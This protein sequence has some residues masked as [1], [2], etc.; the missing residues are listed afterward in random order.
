[1]TNISTPDMTYPV[2]GPIAAIFSSPP[3]LQSQA[4]GRLTRK[5][6]DCS[7]VEV[8]LKEEALDDYLIRLL[9]T[10]QDFHIATTPGP[11]G[12]IFVD[13]ETIPGLKPWQKEIFEKAVDRK[14][15]FGDFPD[16]N[17]GK[18]IDSVLVPIPEDRCHRRGVTHEGYQQLIADAARVYRDA[19]RADTYDERPD[20]V[21]EAQR[22]LVWMVD[23]ERHRWTPSEY[24]EDADGA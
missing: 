4:Q 12:T 20:A 22:K 13:T 1:M 3:H 15:F 8:Q 10:K 17:C 19:I 2:Q 11:D 24:P 14:T 23:A 7:V 16:T 5:P 9:K 21:L 6:E 18:M